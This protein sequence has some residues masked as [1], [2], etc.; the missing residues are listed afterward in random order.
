M[1]CP[2]KYQQWTRVEVV[3]FICFKLKVSQPSQ[4]FFHNSSGRFTAEVF[5]Y[6]CITLFIIVPLILKIKVCLARY[7]VLLE[8]KMDLEAGL[9]EAISQLTLRVPE[10]GNV[11]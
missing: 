10:N 1:N 3:R 7:D 5:A 8:N 2:R 6:L 9:E 4:L 11:E